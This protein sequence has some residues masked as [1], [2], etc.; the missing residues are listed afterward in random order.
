MIGVPYPLE[1]D[2]KCPFSPVSV[3]EVSCTGGMML[4]TPN[5][6]NEAVAV[7]P[8][9]ECTSPSDTRCTA[10]KAAEEILKLKV[11]DSGLAPVVDVEVRT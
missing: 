1:F 8:P 5:G 9:E 11:E 10:I 7:V 3:K 4:V 6:V 2:H